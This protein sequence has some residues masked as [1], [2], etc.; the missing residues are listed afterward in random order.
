MVTVLLSAATFWFEGG[1]T[2]RGKKILKKTRSFLIRVQIKRVRVIC[3]TE[4]NKPMDGRFK[5]K[6]ANT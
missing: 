5:A 2:R 4:S 6:E 1:W 3:R